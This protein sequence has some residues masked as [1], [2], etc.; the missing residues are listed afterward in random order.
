MTRRSQQALAIGGRPCMG[1]LLAVFLVI[2]L[3]L[4]PPGA[5]TVTID[6]YVVE[7]V[8]IFPD[9]TRFLLART[10]EAAWLLHD[11]Q[12]APWLVVAVEGPWLT[13]SGTDG[14]VLDRV[15]V[16]AALGL[17]AEAWWSGEEVAPPGASPLVLA[18]RPDG[19]DVSLDGLLA[20]RLR[21]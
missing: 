13:L 8:G 12:G 3:N 14:T 20:A 1:T 6:D 2:S 5:Q 15:D 11:A 19:V 16:G 21:W 4:A 18:H 7:G 10:D 17:P 9:P